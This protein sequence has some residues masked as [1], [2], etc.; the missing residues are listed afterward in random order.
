M[1][2]KIVAISIFRLDSSINSLCICFTHCVSA[3]RYKLLEKETIAQSTIM[4]SQ[5]DLNLGAGE[6]P[7]FKQILFHKPQLQ[8]SFSCCHCF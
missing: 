3:H 8:V 1:D 6:R 4:S 7:K 5:S 2:E